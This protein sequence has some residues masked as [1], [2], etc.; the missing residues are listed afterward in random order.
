MEVQIMLPFSYIFRVALLFFSEVK[1][2]E[3]RLALT[4]NLNKSFHLP[5]QSIFSGSRNK[6]RWET[7]NGTEYATFA[8][9]QSRETPFCVGH[10]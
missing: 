3:T 7:N 8:L 2:L 6:V 5:H 10:D 4:K 9:A 1:R